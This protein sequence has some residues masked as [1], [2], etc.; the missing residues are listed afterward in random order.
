MGSDTIISANGAVTGAFSRMFNDFATE[1]SQDGSHV[2]SPP[3]G[4]DK[5]VL[6][7][8]VGA[9]YV[10]H[11]VV[12]GA[13]FEYGLA[14]DTTPNLCAYAQACYLIGPGVNFNASGVAQIGSGALS[15]GK[16]TLKG[17]FVD[18][19]PWNLQVLSDG[20]NFQGGRAMQNI[21]PAGAGAGVLVCQQ[22]A[23]C[24]RR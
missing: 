16:S 6:N 11:A 2:S 14:F 12:S 1:M 23:S 8:A 18:K 7:I 22:N 20:K 10:N 19:G 15:H 13:S 24:I 9:N 4:P 21:N 5:A 3:Q 17:A